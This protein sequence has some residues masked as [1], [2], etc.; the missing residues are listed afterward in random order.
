MNNPTPRFTGIFIPVEILE[1][2]DLTLLE[3]MLLSWIDALYCHEHNGCYAKNEYFAEKLKVK[4][5]TI[6]KALTS[7][8]QKGL[9]IDVS[10]DGRNRVIKA[11][12]GVYVEKAQSKAGLDLNPKQGWI[13]IQGRVG[14]LS[15]PSYIESK[16]ESKEDISP[17]IPPQKEAAIADVAIATE[18]ISVESPKEK[19]KRARIPAEFNSATREVGQK[20]LEILTRNKAN[21]VAPKNLAPFLT[22]VD[23]LLRLDQRDPQLI[24]DVFAWAVADSFWSAKMYKPNPAEYL[25]KQFDQLEKQMEVKPIQKERKFLPSSN[26][27]EAAKKLREMNKR[28]L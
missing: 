14:F 18:V 17:P 26:D 1:N 10:F 12:I 27:S 15:N 19:P 25:R 5:N 23:Y 16:E 2:K 11:Q 20:M 21:Y 6:A 4:E 22:H 7:L 9:V 24:Q 28:A 8:R 13:K 3:Q